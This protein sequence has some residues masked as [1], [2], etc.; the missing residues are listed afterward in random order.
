MGN[1]PLLMSLINIISSFITTII[2]ILL[3][4]AF[5]TLLERKILGYSQLRKGPNKVSVSGILQPI[6][7]A[8]K[9]FLKQSI[10]PFRSNK[11][12]FYL[13]PCIRLFLALRLW[14]LYPFPIN[15]L[16]YKYCILIFL[17]ISSINVYSTLLAGWTRNSKYSLIGALRGRA[18]TVSYEVSIALI[19]ICPLIIIISFN[20]NN[21]NQYTLLFSSLSVVFFIWLITLLAETNRTPF[22]LA[23]GE[24][25]LVSGFNTE[26]GS[27]SFALIFI[28]EYINILF[29]SLLSAYIF[30]YTP[31]QSYPLI[32]QI[33]ILTATTTLAI[34]FI[35]ARTSFPR[36]RYDQLITLCWKVFLPVIIPFTFIYFIAA[37]V[38]LFV[39]FYRSLKLLILR[40]Q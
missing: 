24:S 34:F 23:E 33:L 20:T 27:G 6:S 30:F 11:I 21:L 35:W 39:S 31:F 28:A 40:R 22:D 18:Q 2:L 15:P 14:I 12:P 3:S 32:N 4:I 25:E 10:S 26:Y 5:F 19:L 38:L 13:I 37:I 8:I 1:T 17:C 7:D 29:I 16:N 9:L 36:I